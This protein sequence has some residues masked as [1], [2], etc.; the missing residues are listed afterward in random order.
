MV[1]A[2]LATMAFQYDHH[3]VYI[4]GIC[5]LDKVMRWFGEKP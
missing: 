4:V 1:T 2:T 5:V 3:P